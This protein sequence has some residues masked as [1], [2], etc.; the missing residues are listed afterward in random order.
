MLFCSHCIVWCCVITSPPAVS[1]QSF[2]MA[3]YLARQQTSTTLLQ[4]LRAKGIRNPDHSRALIKEKL[5]AD[6]DS[7][8]ATTSLRVSLLCPVHI[9]IVVI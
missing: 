3:V 4:R 9:Y 8:I 1:S 5:T 6:P 2:S 7:E